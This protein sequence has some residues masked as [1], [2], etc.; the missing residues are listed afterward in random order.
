MGRVVRAR[1]ACNPANTS[2][3][4]LAEERGQCGQVRTAIPVKAP[5]GVL[6]QTFPKTWAPSGRGHPNSTSPAPDQG[7]ALH[8]RSAGKRGKVCGH[9]PLGERSA[10]G[11]I[12]R[13]GGLKAFCRSCAIRGTQ[14]IS[15][16]TAATQQCGCVSSATCSRNNS[17]YSG[18]CHCNSHTDN[19]LI[20]LGHR[21]RD[22]PLTVA[23]HYR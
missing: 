23:I 8:Q 2:S 22:T 13:P 10:S 3:R 12:S 17:G 19:R 16:T 6:S 14:E 11:T 15:T 21:T 18:R 20:V 4:V 9:R 5:R 7:A 1:P